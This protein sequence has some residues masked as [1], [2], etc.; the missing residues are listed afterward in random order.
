MKSMFA[1]LR[2]IALGKPFG[3]DRVSVTSNKNLRTLA[4]KTH[5]KTERSN[6][7][8]NTNCVMLTTYLNDH[9]YVLGG[10]SLSIK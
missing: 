6:F 4:F 3:H 2:F 8:I 1:K 9:K 7:L 10:L 5:V